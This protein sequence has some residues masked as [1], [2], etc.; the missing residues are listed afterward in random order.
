RSAVDRLSD[1]GA[2]VEEARPPVDFDEQRGLFGAMITAAM[3]PSLPPEVAENVSGTHRQW[4]EREKDRARLRRG[5]AEWFETYDILLCPVSPTAALPRDEEHDFMSRKMVVNGEDRSYLDNV[6]W[7]GLIGILGLPSAIPPLGRTDAGLP[8][9]V[10][11][12]APYL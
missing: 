9:G 8:V 12:V 3:S 4:L 11:V 6:G 7:T 10:Q 1:A 5:W 2:K